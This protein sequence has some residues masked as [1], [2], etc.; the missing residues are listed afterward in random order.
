MRVTKLRRKLPNPGSAAA[1]RP[2]LR[3]L[4]KPKTCFIRQDCGFRRCLATIV[5]TGVVIGAATLTAQQGAAPAVTTRDL[6]D[7]LKDPSRW[8]SY[9]GDYNG[10]RHSPLTQ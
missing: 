8:L 1:R 4:L 5:L 10:D 9:G 7:G 6:L 2:R 3:Q